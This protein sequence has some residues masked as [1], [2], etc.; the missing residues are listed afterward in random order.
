MTL[1]SASGPEA[2]FTKAQASAS[3]SGVV[4]SFCAAIRYVC[5]GM[6]V[7]F[8]GEQERFGHGG[9]GEQTYP[10]LKLGVLLVP[11]DDL[12]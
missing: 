2:C 12:F 10:G 8:D 1:K 7:S 9:Q 4:V 5:S 3:S 6:F 11:V